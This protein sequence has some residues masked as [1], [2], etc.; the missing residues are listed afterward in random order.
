M[1]LALDKKV[2]Y[3]PHCFFAAKQQGSFC[4]PFLNIPNLYNRRDMRRSVSRGTHLASEIAEELLSRPEFA[5]SH[6]VMDRIAGVALRSLPPWDDV[7]I[8]PLPSAAEASTCATC[9]PLRAPF[10]RLCVSPFFREDSLI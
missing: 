3:Y 6:Q 8:T 4:F 10:R 5:S 9:R 7:N 2:F 1:P